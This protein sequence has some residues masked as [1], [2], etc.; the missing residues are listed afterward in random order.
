MEYKICKLSWAHNEY[1]VLSR[2]PGT[3]W[4]YVVKSTDKSTA[5]KLYNELLTTL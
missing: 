3:G 2:A 1:A 5:E 4:V